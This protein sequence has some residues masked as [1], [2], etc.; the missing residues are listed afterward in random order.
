MS[1]TTTTDVVVVGA[2]A[3]GLV[4][5]VSAGLAGARTIVLEKDP[6]RLGGTMRKSVGALWAPGNRFM[7]GADDKDG[8]LAYMARL[9][10]PG[11]YDPADPH[12]GLAAWEHALLSAFYEHG[13]SVLQTLEGAG[14]FTLSP[15]NDPDNFG[16][17]PE[18]M[19]PQGR[20]LYPYAPDGP[21]TG[22]AALTAGLTATAERLGVEL[23]RG[24]AVIDLLTE[25]RAITGVLAETAAGEQVEIVARGG[26]VFAS[27][28]FAHDA[29][30][31]LECFNAPYLPGCSALTDTGDF[32]HIARR[33]GVHLVNMS[34]VWRAPIVVERLLREPDT[35]MASFHIPGDGQ[36]AVNRAGRRFVNEKAPYN[37]F[38]RAC[39]EIDARQANYPNLPLILIADRRQIDAHGD[40]GIG[41]PFV[42]A[43]DDAYWLVR[44]DTL[45][46]LGP[47]LDERLQQLGGRFGGARI[48]A[49]FTTTLQATVERYDRMARAG[50]D[51]DFARGETPYEQHIAGKVGGDGP[52]LA[53]RPLDAQGPYYATLVGPCAFDTKGGARTDPDG[54]VFDVRGDAIEG[55]YAAGNCAASP[56]VEAY[57]SGGSSLGL[58]FC[59]G[60]RAGR[61]AAQRAPATQ[62]ARA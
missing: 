60:F 48:S 15:R 34:Q 22:G 59:F 29:G 6:E 3:A 39:F 61:A 20:K 23:R 52:N 2:G 51:E 55:L 40:S 17:L 13:A 45:A 33:L 26:V 27:G 57:W 1:A 41:N 54:R 16:H 19:A 49:D 58:A 8:A 12:L 7:D 56:S 62:P 43:A 50:R 25:D 30:L 42:S 14:A 31:R 10:R 44:A 21:A 46:E 9:S 5:A 18:N 37:E 28:G 35:V 24:H 38:T 11:S 4:A 53:L 47:L 36:L 32:V